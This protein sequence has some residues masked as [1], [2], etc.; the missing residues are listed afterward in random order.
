MK[1]KRA[2]RSRPNEA[3][4][5]ESAGSTELPTRRRRKKKR[6]SKKT[7]DRS[8]VSQIPMGSTFDDVFRS[9]ASIWVKIGVGAVAAPLFVLFYGLRGGR[10]GAMDIREHPIA[11]TVGMLCVA[12]VGGFL[13]AALTFKDVVSE[14]MA[15]GQHVPLPLK[16]LFGYGMKSLLLVWVPLV[17]ILVIVV[18][19]LY[20]IATL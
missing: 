11:S 6:G 5:D 20:W 15:N 18:P 19:M 1:K 4:S 17:F 9:G 7:A 14:R 2:K 16:L 8:S 3:D 13:S 12:V 10:G